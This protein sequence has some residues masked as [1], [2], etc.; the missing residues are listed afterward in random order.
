MNEM[1]TPREP[2]NIANESPDL[3][4]YICETPSHLGKGPTV[5]RVQRLVNLA[6]L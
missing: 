2:L 3:Q 6:S 4:Y 5:N 1:A